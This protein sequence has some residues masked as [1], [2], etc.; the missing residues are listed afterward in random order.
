MRETPNYQKSRYDDFVTSPGSLWSPGR[1]PP[2]TTL[3]FQKSLQLFLKSRADYPICLSLT[4]LTLKREAKQVA[5]AHEYTS[6]A[7]DLS[8]APQEMGKASLLSCQSS[9]G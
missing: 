6:L 4:H 8:G 1:L 7:A 3:Y 5:K 2:C 9:G